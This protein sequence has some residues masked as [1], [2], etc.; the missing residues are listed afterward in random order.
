MKR[1]TLF[2]LSLTALAGV[3][4]Q[5]TK[6]GRDLDVNISTVQNLFAPTDGLS[7]T[8][9]PATSAAVVF[10]W[11]QA[12]AEDGTLVLYE[13]A[14]D[15][16]TGDFSKPVYKMTSDQNG[17]LNQ[18]TI[19]HKDL[20][21][22]AALAGV[23]SL[24]TGTLKWTVLASRG[25]NVKPATQTRTI[26]LTRPAGFDVVP[27]SVFLTGSATEAGTDVAKAIPMK[28]TGPGTFEVYTSLKPGTYSFVDRV[29]GTAKT[30]SVS[31]VNIKEG[32][33]ATVTD[34]QQP[35]RIRLDFTNA[36]ASLTQIKEMGL[37]YSNDNDIRFT[38]DYV[39]GGVWQA[40]NKPIVFP[41]VPWGKEDRYKFRL[42]TVTN[43][44]AGEEWFGSS[45][46]DNSRPDAN[47]PNSYFYLF[48]IAPSQWDYSYKFNGAADGK[49]N[50]I[51][52]SLAPAGPY[53]H[54]V[55]TN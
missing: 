35:V 15:Q 46:S 48:P 44:T 6:P 20:N 29:S 8:L 2:L 47:T 28:S 43:G 51:T 16:T 3:L 14:F 53:F 38:L 41:T 24:G 11:D 49:T 1:I 13:V 37:W 10:Q 36:A 5:C 7:V 26:T 23:G 12:R 34:A 18:A 50:T 32:G 19:S 40:A 55:K 4:T 25:I 27:T 22:I 42:K 52:V 54:T 45:N 9:Q 30:Y 31:G 33:T 39:G 21:R 17:V